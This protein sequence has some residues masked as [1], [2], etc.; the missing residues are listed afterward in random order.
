M[1]YGP[2]H[3]CS[4]GVEVGLKVRDRPARAVCS[5]VSVGANALG[6]LTD[7]QSESRNQSDGAAFQ[8]NPGGA[9]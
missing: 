3:A 2:D 6:D 7:L 9:K 5:S 4:H 8:C 1:I